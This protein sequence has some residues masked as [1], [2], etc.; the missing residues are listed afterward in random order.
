MP[1]TKLT[2]KYCE[3]KHPPI[4]WTRAAILERQAVLGYDLKRLAAVGGISYD[5]MRRLIR[6]SPW[7]WPA[8]VRDRI[9]DELGVKLVVSVE[10]L[11]E[12]LR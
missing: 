8:G 5:Y 12:A 9:C 11:P 1:R 6:I 4:D 7:E 2:A 3:P 10:G